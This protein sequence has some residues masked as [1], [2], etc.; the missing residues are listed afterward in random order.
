MRWRRATAACRSWSRSPSSIAG[1][2][3]YGVMKGSA[4]YDLAIAYKEMG[5]L[6]DAVAELEI[7]R[8]AGRMPVESFAVLLAT[9]KLG[10]GRP[11]EAAVVLEEALSGAG[12]DES[13]VS[14][15]Y[16]L[17]EA[18]L[19]AGKPAEALD[20]FRKVASFDPNYRDVGERISEL[21]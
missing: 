4:N 21:G 19:A 6:D 2:S 20:A 8:R 7:V 18:L 16:E 9:C 10:L 5:L 15:R 14:L 3:G 11:L 1:V 12:D 17:G 13:T